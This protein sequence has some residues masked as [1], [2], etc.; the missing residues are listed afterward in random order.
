[1]DFELKLVIRDKG[2]FLLIQ[3]AIPQEEITITNLYAPN[4][5]AHN[6]IKHMLKDLKPHIGPNILEVGDFNIS[7]SPIDRSSTPKKKKN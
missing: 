1:V 5:T 3:G 7:L 2:H 4:V 6:F